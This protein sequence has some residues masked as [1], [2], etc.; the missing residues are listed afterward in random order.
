MPLLSNRD[1]RCTS[2]VSVGSAVMQIS[3]WRHP[4]TPGYFFFSDAGSFLSFSK[5][6]RFSARETETRWS[7]NGIVCVCVCASL[8]L[9][10]CRLFIVVLKTGGWVIS[11]QRVCSPPA[12]LSLSLSASLFLL[13][14]SSPLPLFGPTYFTSAYNLRTHPSPPFFP[15]RGE[16]E[17]RKR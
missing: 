15:Q 13:L 5:G 16:S 8:W 3:I 6:F 2:C 12:F 7:L 14:P 1:N 10:G 11:V 9:K 4:V 17:P